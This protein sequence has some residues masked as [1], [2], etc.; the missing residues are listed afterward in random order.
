MYTIVITV[1]TNYS[2]GHVTLT[3][4]LHWTSP[5]GTETYLFFAV[6]FGLFQ[7]VIKVSLISAT[8]SWNCTIYKPFS[9]ESSVGAKLSLIMLKIKH[10][11]FEMSSSHAEAALR[12]TLG[13][14]DSQF[15][16]HWKVCAT[17]HK[18]KGH[19]GKI[20]KSCKRLCVVSDW[21]SRNK[22]Y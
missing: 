20:L 3:Y 21:L 9:R 11:L 7:I 8:V 4:L 2:N 6:P 12:L 5:P 18:H 13:T 15:K 10:I 16:K 19:T 1:M 14:L 22:S 17:F